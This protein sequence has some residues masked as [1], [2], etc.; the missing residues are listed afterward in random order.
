MKT[1]QAKTPGLLFNLK[2]GNQSPGQHFLHKRLHMGNNNAYT[3]QTNKYQ[4]MELK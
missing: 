3:L 4:S 2:P 1:R